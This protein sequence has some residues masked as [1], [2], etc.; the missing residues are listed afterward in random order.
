MTRSLRVRPRKYR[1]SD[2]EGVINAPKMGEH[3]I[4]EV[5]IDVVLRVVVLSS[6]GR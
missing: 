3:T 1:L 2:V 4:I 5:I 6:I